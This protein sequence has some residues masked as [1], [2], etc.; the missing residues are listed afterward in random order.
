MRELFFLA[1]PPHQNHRDYL[2]S[3]PGYFCDGSQRAAE[4]GKTFPQ[5]HPLSWTHQISGNTLLQW[6]LNLR[7]KAGKQFYAWVC[8]TQA[9]LLC[10]ISIKLKGWENREV[11]TLM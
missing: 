10:L 6:K 11:T 4:T 9:I 1:R 5:S 2:V 8:I 3:S 7:E